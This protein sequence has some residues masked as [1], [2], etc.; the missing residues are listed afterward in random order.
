MCANM[1]RASDAPIA[2]AASTYSRTLCLRYSARISRKIP[3]Q[4]V[5]PRIRI[6]REDALLAEHRRDREHQQQVGIEVN[7]L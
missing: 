5:R 4:P 7:T 6:D 1:R 3:V 2:S